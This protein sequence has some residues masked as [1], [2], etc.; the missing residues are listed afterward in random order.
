MVHGMAD[1]A[2]SGHHGGLVSAQNRI[3]KNLKGRRESAAFSPAPDGSTM[4]RAKRLLRGGL[5]RLGLGR[6]DRP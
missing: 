5:G 1:G 6:F 2:I 3:A 4:A